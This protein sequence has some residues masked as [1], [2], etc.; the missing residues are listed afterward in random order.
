MMALFLTLVLSAVS[1]GLYLLLARRWQIL[2]QP[3]ERSSH[4]L[5]TPHGGGVPLL[6]SASV[7][8]LLNAWWGEPWGSGFVL[9]AVLALFLML[10]G[11]LDD[12]RGLSVRLRFGLYALCSLVVA[13]AL[14]QPQAPAGWITVF[15]EIMPIRY[16]PPR[17]ILV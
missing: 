1:C 15:G 5:P 4:H 9:L 17:I 6:L 16:K 14:L 8:F 12:L 3:N 7:G 10:L 13:V 11:V 2:D